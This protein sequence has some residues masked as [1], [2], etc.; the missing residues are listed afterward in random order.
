MNF[1]QILLHVVA[2]LRNYDTLHYKPNYLY[3]YEPGISLGARNPVGEG[4][5][6]QITEGLV[7]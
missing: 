5:R 3:G 4:S 1:L 2:L 7:Y 6:G